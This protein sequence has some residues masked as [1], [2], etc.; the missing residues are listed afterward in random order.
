V[1]E[2]DSNFGDCRRIK[3]GTISLAKKAAIVVVV[4]SLGITTQILCVVKLW[5]QGKYTTD[6]CDNDTLSI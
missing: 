3:I 1:F 6:T 2:C 4:G 5:S